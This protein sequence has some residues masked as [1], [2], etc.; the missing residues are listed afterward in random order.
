MP[1]SSS[2]TTV[3]HRVAGPVVS[4]AAGLD[5]SWRALPVAGRGPLLYPAD[6]GGPAGRRER[7]QRHTAASTGCVGGRAC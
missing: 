3:A 4:R 7:A 2:S 6:L 1:L 5:E